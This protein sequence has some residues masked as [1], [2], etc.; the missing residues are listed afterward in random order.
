M[1]SEGHDFD[2]DSFADAVNA[3]RASMKLNKKSREKLAPQCR[4]VVCGNK[5]TNHC[6]AINCPTEMW[7]DGKQCWAIVPDPYWQQTMVRVLQQYRIFLAD[8]M[9]K[10]G[11][12]V[13]PGTLE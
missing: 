1:V 7:K 5:G 10:Y 4:E 11:V 12:I 9:A 8:R 2:L 13:D 6:F 3:K